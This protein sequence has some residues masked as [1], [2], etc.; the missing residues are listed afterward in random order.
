MRYRPN[1][2]LEELRKNI[3]NSVWKKYV[4]NGCVDIAFTP[5][6]LDLKK[7]YPNFLVSKIINRELSPFPIDVKYKGQRRTTYVT[8]F[9]RGDM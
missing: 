3:L 8:K 1:H 2:D 6:N 5:K 4:D 9:N 7:E